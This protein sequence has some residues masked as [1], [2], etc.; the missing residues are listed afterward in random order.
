MGRWS[1]YMR[2]LRRDV[3]MAVLLQI[4]TCMKKQQCTELLG[5]SVYSDLRF[6]DQV[7]FTYLLLTIAA[8]AARR[9]TTVSRIVKTFFLL[10]ASDVSE[11]RW[12]HLRLCLS[13]PR[14]SI[15]YAAVVRSCC[16][17]FFQHVF[18]TTAS[19]AASR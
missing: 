3:Q 9:E 4:R 7:A 1:S 12:F 10:G 8:S 13:E 15:R 18:L 2:H 17:S 14:F 16:C 6:I 19:R 11:V 5:E